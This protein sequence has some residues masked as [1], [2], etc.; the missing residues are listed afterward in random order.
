MGRTVAERQVGLSSDGR[1]G[2]AE[3]V[4]EAELINLLSD[5]VTL[6]EEK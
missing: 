3:A 4:M 6:K 5:G 1:I 2:L